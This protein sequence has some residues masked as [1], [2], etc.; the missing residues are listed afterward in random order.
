VSAAKRPMITAYWLAVGRFRGIQIS[1]AFRNP[2]TVRRRISALMGLVRIALT[3]DGGAQGSPVIRMI[4]TRWM[5]PS[6]PTRRRKSYPSITGINRSSRIN[7]GGSSHVRI[8][9]SAL[10][11]FSAGRTL[12]PDCLRNSHNAWRV[13]ESS[14]TTRIVPAA[15]SIMGVSDRLLYEPSDALAVPSNYRLPRYA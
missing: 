6:L 5:R 10:R 13:S 3:P 8:S 1:A 4:G 15:K 2:R 12:Y 9:C 11:P 14:S 7:A